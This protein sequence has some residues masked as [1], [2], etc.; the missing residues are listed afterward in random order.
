[1][2]A[3]QCPNCGKYTFKKAFSTK[4][5]GCFMILGGIALPP[6]VL[7]GAAYHGGTVMGIGFLELIG[8]LIAILGL[9]LF[10]KSFISP[11][12][13]VSYTCSDCKFSENYKLVIKN[14][15]EWIQNQIESKQF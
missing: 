1:M 10:V 14:E 6:M 5:S 8:L 11:D 7:G 15:N 9:I 2:S 13:T 3:E 12:K 4:T